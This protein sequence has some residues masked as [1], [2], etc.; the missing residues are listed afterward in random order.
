MKTENDHLKATIENL[1]FK[2]KR[3]AKENQ[4]LVNFANN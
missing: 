2:I 1:K 3:L 4:K